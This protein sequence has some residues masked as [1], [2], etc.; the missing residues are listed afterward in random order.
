MRLLDTLLINLIKLPFLLRLSIVLL[1]YMF[2]FILYLF[3]QFNGPL[4]ALP[5][6][7]AVWLFPPRGAL[8][9]TI[10][11]VL[12]LAT[13]ISLGS[14][15][16][17][18]PAS[19][20]LGFFTGTFALLT[21]AIFIYYLR[22]LLNRAE[23]ARLE[24]LHT[25]RQRRIAY[26]LQL[27]AQQAQQRLSM[28]YEQQKQLNQLKDRFILNVSHELRTP[29]QTVLGYIELL[30]S[31]DEQ[32]DADIRINCL[33]QAFNAC[34]ELQLLVNNVLDTVQISLGEQVPEKEE[35]IV[36]QIVQDVLALVDPQQL[37]NF[38]LRL[39]IPPEL[40]V[41]ADPQQIR[42][43]VRNLLTNGLK[44][45]PAPGTITI[46][47][48]ICKMEEA[49]ASPPQ[50]CI[51]VQDTGP[52]IPAEEIPFIFERFVRLKRDISGSVRG[53]GLGLSISKELVEAMGGRIWVESS[54]I[55]GE[56]CR[57]YFT[58]P[59]ATTAIHTNW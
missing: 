44:Y 10:F 37:K 47:A 12:L 53:T 1:C 39:D 5:I 24:V 7:L 17:F 26:E 38:T 42:Q 52:G 32:L 15:S 40:R 2:C 14:R 43:V 30:Q 55:P 28:A 9:S 18:W 46:T 16:I 59:N 45:C 19:L 8:V 21:E 6:A 20:L 25:E 51:C 3:S 58:L 54:G 50:V 49:D 33:N 35:I 29:V 41:I 27:E 31:F 48:E 34:Q 36:Q 13:A 23:T 4:W 22:H 11:T 56:G 57:F